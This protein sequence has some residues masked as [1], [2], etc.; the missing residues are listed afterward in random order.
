MVN[1]NSEGFLVQ[2]EY[3]GGFV[4]TKAGLNIQISD[5]ITSTG[6]QINL[7]RE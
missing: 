4:K 1:Y 5:F 2:E 6:L 3:L 7:I